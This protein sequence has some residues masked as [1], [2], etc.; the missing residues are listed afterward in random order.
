MEKLL[1]FMQLMFKKF[2]ISEVDQVRCKDN[3]Y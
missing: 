1:Q 3:N 2:R